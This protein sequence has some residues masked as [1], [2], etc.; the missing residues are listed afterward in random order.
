VEPLHLGAGLS[1]E[2]VMTA[3][4]LDQQAQRTRTAA[5]RDRIPRTAWTSGLPLD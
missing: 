2:S 5:A 1:P 3:A 4:A